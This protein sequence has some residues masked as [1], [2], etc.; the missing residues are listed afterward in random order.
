MKQKGLKNS[1]TGRQGEKNNIHIT[2]V[3]EKEKK[4]NT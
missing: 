4:L 1:G 3:P 2:G